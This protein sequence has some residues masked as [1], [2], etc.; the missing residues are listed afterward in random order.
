MSGLGTR[1]PFVLVLGS[2]H[3][4]LYNTKVK[5]K[6]SM[7]YFAYKT[8]KR[9]NDCLLLVLNQK[10]GMKNKIKHYLLLFNKFAITHVG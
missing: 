1:Y 10:V 3:Q 8:W 9:C 6:L 7:A 2:L 4:I 5:V